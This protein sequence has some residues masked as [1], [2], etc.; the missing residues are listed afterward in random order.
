MRS[1]TTPVSSSGVTTT[2]GGDCGLWVV[3]IYEAPLLAIYDT[4]RLV[5]WAAALSGL[6]MLFGSDIAFSVWLPHICLWVWVIASADVSLFT[7]VY[8]P[9]T[10]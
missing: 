4:P 8:G 3:T 7:G 5:A 10:I 9:H 1:K 6:S 2:Y